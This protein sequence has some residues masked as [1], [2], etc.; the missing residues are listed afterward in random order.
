M[1][2]DAADVRGAAQK[3]KVPGTT[4]SL[5]ADASRNRERILAAARDVFVEEG[6]GAPL[7]DIAKRAG[8]GI[9]TLYRR[10]P[11]RESLM[12]GVALDI[13]GQNTDEARLALAEE[14]DAVS[15]LA[16][17]LHRALDIRISAVFS[18]LLGQI[19]MDD[20]EIL[21]LRDESTEPVQRMIELAQAEGTLRPDVAFGDIGTI[22]VRLS[23]PLPGRFPRDLDDGLAHRHLDLLID[24]LRVVSGRAAAG[25]SGPAM[26]LGDLRSMEPDAGAD[27]HDPTKGPR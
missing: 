20:A 11:D 23:R 4:P 26:T 9:A 1:K 17:Y 18:A 12:R 8:V 27:A 2:Q 10:F 6:A 7:E 13:L 15:A 5:R 24:G 3:A 14:P 19:P 25:L 21:R 16:R 22:L